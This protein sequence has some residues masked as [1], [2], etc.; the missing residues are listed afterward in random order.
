MS[1]IRTQE[2]IDDEIARQDAFEDARSVESGGP[3]G[4]TY[5]GTEI[6]GGVV[7]IPENSCRNPCRTKQVKARRSRESSRQSWWLC[8]WGRPGRGRCPI[9]WG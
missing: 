3:S 9:G 6:G 4:L 2:E 7:E 5:G 1:D 8:Y